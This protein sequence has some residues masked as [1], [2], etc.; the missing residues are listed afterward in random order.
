VPEPFRSLASIFARDSA[1][2]RFVTARAPQGP[3]ER[4]AEPPV[5][6]AAAADERIAELLDT[7]VSD[8]ARLRARAAERFEEC[9]EAMLT[10]LARRVLGR[11]LTI[12]PPEIEA[13]LAQA[14]GEFDTASGVIV[15]VCPDDAQR[16][17]AQWPVRAEAGLAV[18]DFAVE[19]DDGRYEAALQ[20]RLEAL[21][22]AHRVAL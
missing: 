2:E 1:A 18:G 4:A 13:L 6:P 14:L 10:D 12:A 8:L 20:T 7:F 3:R 22:A 21:L 15:R 17:G 9:A 16:L 11:E 19:V 5:V